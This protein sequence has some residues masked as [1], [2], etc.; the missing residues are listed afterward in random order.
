MTKEFK[1]GILAVV[2][3]AVSIWGY[4]FILGRN[5]LTRSTTI[6]VE[7]SNVGEIRES[8]P[9]Y[10]KGLQVGVVTSIYPRDRDMKSF[11]VVIQL[12]K[13]IYVP[14]DAVVEIRTNSVMG[15]K[16]LEI[17]FNKGCEGDCAVNGDTLR[18]VTL[19]MLRSMVDSSE[20]AMFLDLMGLKMTGFVDSLSGSIND[21]NNPNSI[22]RT[23]MDLRATIANLKSISGK[24]DNILAGSTGNVRQIT[25]NLE[26]LSATLSKSESRINSILGNLDTTTANLKQVNLAGTVEKAEGAM[27]TLEKTL[28]SA[29]TTFAE[30]EVII[31]NIRKGE[32]TLGK[33]V[34]DDELYNQL[35]ETLM[36]IEKLA[37]DL[38]L[39]PKRYTR[40]LSKKEIPYQ[41]GEEMKNEK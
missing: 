25:N 40:I 3:V 4:K 19:G 36:Q 38:K 5:I 15:S 22:N 17:V 41:P 16:A 20:A 29:S 13:G 7:Y 30:L 24:I 31:A 6:Y 11:F 34:A 23:Y 39:H 2:V 21:P 8:T 35:D 32:G 28:N 10:V 12:D 14:K 9:V 27:E 1:I 37:E 26:K 33:L 18:G